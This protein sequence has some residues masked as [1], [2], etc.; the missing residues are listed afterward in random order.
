MIYVVS[1]GSLTGI[2]GCPGLSRRSVRRGMRVGSNRNV[3]A[4]GMSGQSKGFVD[5]RFDAGC[6]NGGVHFGGGF[7]AIHDTM[8]LL[9]AQPAGD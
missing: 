2:R 7:D 3:A 9:C 6:T 1:T 5:T 4:S 8:P